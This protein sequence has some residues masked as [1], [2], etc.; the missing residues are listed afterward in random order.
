MAS[1]GKEMKQVVPVET[2]CPSW[3][4]FYI[5]GFGG[6]KHGGFDPRIDAHEDEAEDAN[7]VE[8]HLGDNINAE[9]AELGGLIGFNYQWHHL[10]FGLEADGGY[11]WL[12]NSEKERFLIPGSD[13]IYA[14][15]SSFKTHYLVTVGPR[16]GYAFCKWLPYVTGGVAFGDLD[17]RERISETDDWDQ[18]R[19]KSGDNVGFFVGGGLQYALT[20]HWS[21]R[22]QYQYID[23]GDIGLS[24]KVPDEFKAGTK[25]DLREH[26]ASFALIYGF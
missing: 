12:R 4:G 3:T 20:H 22:A 2:A 6:Y 10:V 11:L 24:F 21:V 15:S 14:L 18:S 5:G 1:S 25:M 26:N 8:S 9:G 23:L 19:S 17:F 7:Q 13:D 16:F